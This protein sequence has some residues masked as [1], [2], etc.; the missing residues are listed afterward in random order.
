MRQTVVDHVRSV[1]VEVRVF[2]IQVFKELSVLNLDLCFF[3]SELVIILI[4]L[5]LFTTAL[6]CHLESES[7]LLHIKCTS[8]THCFFVKLR[9]QHRIIN[10]TTQIH[11]KTAHVG[12]HVAKLVSQF[13]TLRCEIRVGE[14]EGL[15]RGVAHVLRRWPIA[16]V[17]AAFKA[18]P[19]IV[20]AW[21]FWPQDV[22]HWRNNIFPI[23]PLIGHVF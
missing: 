9:L 3:L 16:V 4:V 14:G 18:V 13:H 1:Q 22:R 8:G 15:H 11:S 17:L 7:V 23:V 21:G 19:R 12:F 20:L 5:K 6:F 10:L 2:Q